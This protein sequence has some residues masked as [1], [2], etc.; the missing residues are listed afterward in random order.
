VDIPVRCRFGPACR[1]MF[2]F[3]HEIEISCR[4]LCVGIVHWDPDPFGSGPFWP[5]RIMD[6]DPE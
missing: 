3:L 2:L 1:K 6:P 4:A 5:D